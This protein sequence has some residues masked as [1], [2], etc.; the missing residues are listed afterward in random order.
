MVTYAEHLKRILTQV[1]DSYETLA[2]VE[3]HPLGLDCLKKE[4]LRINGSLK[5]ILSNIDASKIRSSDY[6]PLCSKF[7]R[8]LDNYDFEGEMA[9]MASLYSEDSM[10]VNNMRIKILEA[11]CD[12][13]M[14]EYIRYVID[15]L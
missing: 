3:N 6:A 15:D 2:D 4:M 10:R 8:Y 12:R 1:L 5:A 11:L 13:K 14:I 9:A 7:R